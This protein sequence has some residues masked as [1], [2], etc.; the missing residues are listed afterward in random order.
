MLQKMHVKHMH[1]PKTPTQSPRCGGNT[2][3]TTTK[4]IFTY[5]DYQV[6]VGWVFCLGLGVGVGHF[7]FTVILVHVVR[8]Q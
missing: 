7:L 5:G 1:A 6:W 8:I 2:T 4:N 3:K